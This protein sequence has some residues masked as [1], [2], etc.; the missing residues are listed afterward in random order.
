MRISFDIDDTLVCP[1]ADAPNEPGWVPNFI[2]GWL[3]EP[4]RQ[5]TRLLFQE[6]RR[7]GFSIWIYT[8]SVRTPFQIRLWLILHGIRVDGVINEERHRTQLAG[9]RFAR[10]PSKYPPAFGID[11]HVDDSEGVKMEG[12]EHGFLVVLVRPNDEHWGKV[13]LGAIEQVMDASPHS[14]DRVEHLPA[15][16]Q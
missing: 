9:R 14:R 2:H 1:R 12:Q 15:K 4:L 5:G 6:L 11:L 3:G 10:V 7:R 13:V 16:P 8:T